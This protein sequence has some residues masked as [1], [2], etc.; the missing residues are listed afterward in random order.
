MRHGPALLALALLAPLAAWIGARDGDRGSVTGPAVRFAVAWL[1]AF[2]LVT[3]PAVAIWSSY[4]Y[5]TAAVGGALLIGLLFRRID[6]L[7]WLALAA[8]LLWWHAGATSNRSFAVGAG[9]WV[10]TSHLTSYYFERVAELTTTMKQ[11]LVELEPSPPRG[12]RFFFATLPP[13]AGFQLGNGP[14]IRAVYRDTTLGS[15]FYSSFSDTT[16]A[17]R[18]T[19]FL[20]WTGT[21]F[22]RLYANARDPL[23]QVGGDLLLLGRPAN[24]AYAFRRALEEGGDRMDNLY[25]L[26]WA[27]MFRGNRPAAEAAWQTFGARDDS[28][29][30]MAHLRAA[31][32]LLITERDTI[33][34]RRHLIK[35]IEFGIGRPEGHA[36][37]GALLMQQRPKYALLELKVASWLKPED[38]LARREFFLGLVRARLDDAARREL[39]ALLQSTPAWRADTTLVAA[40]ELIERRTGGVAMGR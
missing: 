1:I 31:R 13:W 10:W 2:G 24:A 8:G 7:G 16:A 6:R 27:E 20:Y 36:V 34:A 11:E 19:R 23:F 18:P 37:L 29:Y 3:G 35:S 28:L 22:D 32:R 5:T 17:G 21:R 33:E 26:G 12:T 4:Y 9:P 39:P 30:W 40:I 15:H 14:L 38:R 25:W